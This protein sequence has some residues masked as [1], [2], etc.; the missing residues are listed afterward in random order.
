MLKR[1]RRQLAREFPE[2]IELSN[3]LALAAVTWRK[4]GISATDL[5][6]MDQMKVEML[7]LT[8]LEG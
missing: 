7:W 3:L 1:L 2:Y 8:L 6:K 5:Q 4:Y